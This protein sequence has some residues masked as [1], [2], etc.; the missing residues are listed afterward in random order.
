[1]SNSSGFYD[2]VYIGQEIYDMSSKKIVSPY[3]FHNL[4]LMIPVA[5]T[6]FAKVDS[7]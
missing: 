4:Y 3:Y 1:M 7:Y 6:G 5:R 2:I